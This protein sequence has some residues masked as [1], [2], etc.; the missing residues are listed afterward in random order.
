MFRNYLKIAIRNLYKNKLY[1][2]V[3]IIGLTIGITSCLLI[4]IYIAHE[5]SYDRFHKNA[6][7]I[8]RVTMDYNFGRLGNDP[9]NH[10]ILAFPDADYFSNWVV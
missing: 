9:C 2:S 8:V 4:G 7:R 6:D 5:L 1:S 10:K 3:N